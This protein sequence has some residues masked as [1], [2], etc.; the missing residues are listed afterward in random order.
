VQHLRRSHQ[1][2]TFAKDAKHHVLRIFKA[3]E[4]LKTIDVFWVYKLHSRGNP[5]T[6]LNAL[7]MWKSL[8]QGLGF[9]RILPE[10]A[11]R[12]V[13]E[14]H[15]CGALKAVTDFNSRDA[16]FEHRHDP[17]RQ[18]V[19]IDDEVRNKI[20]KAVRWDASGRWKQYNQRYFLSATEIKHPYGIL[21]YIETLPHI[22][23]TPSS[24]FRQLSVSK[25][26]IRAPAQRMTCMRERSP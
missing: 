16:F 4:L 20:A 10:R 21:S 15:D 1:C 13:E 24:R 6:Q 18:I 8:A 2:K 19:P 23:P 22:K 7:G 5:Y 25:T 3:R 9:K 14:K 12:V 26:I 11:T 17:E